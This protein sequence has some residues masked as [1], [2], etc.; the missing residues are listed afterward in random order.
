[1]NLCLESPWLEMADIASKTAKKLYHLNNGS[2]LDE[3]D[4]AHE[5]LLKINRALGGSL[6][7]KALMQTI[8]SRRAHDLIRYHN[9]RV[10]PSLNEEIEDD[11][12]NTVEKVELIVG[13][14]GFE[15]QVLTMVDI[16]RNIP[17]DIIKIA[18]KRV[19]GEPI[20]AAERKKLERFRKRCHET[21]L[22]IRYV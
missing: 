4:F 16:E 14:Q 13:C 10:H 18:W 6:K 21:R 12:G 17:R 3:D 9:R 5:I 20:S 7:D 1:M 15:E 11:E 19:K 8:A 22:D 2:A